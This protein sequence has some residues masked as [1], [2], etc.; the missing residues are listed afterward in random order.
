MRK[1]LK[2]IILDKQEEA[3]NEVANKQERLEEVVTAC[4][5]LYKK[6]NE[7]TKRVK[8]YK[9]EI[10]K[11][12]EDLHI[13]EYTSSDGSKVTMSVIDKTSIDT[14]QLIN[15]LKEKGLAQ[16]IHTKEYVDEKL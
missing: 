5:E 2:N 10:K 1:T 3:K 15:Y 11:L 12:F 7:L 6:N 9:D 13:L 16:F 4:C 8:A 14:E